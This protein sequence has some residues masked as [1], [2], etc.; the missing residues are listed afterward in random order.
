M[1][2]TIDRAGR[3]VIPKPIR[4]RFHLVAGSRLE[5]ETDAEGIRLRP[6]ESGAMS[7]RRERGLLIH[8]GDGQTA[9]I[10]IVEFIRN[11]RENRGDKIE[12]PIA[13]ES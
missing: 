10:D 12:N 1:A 8:T 3:L 5:I 4:D 6:A 9:D 7:L 2:I 13:G 11:E